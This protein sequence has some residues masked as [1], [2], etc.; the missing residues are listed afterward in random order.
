MA[1][2]KVEAKMVCS[3]CGGTGFDLRV[4][5]NMK[6]CPAGCRSPKKK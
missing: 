3:S 4:E 5:D 2:K 6:P 1:K